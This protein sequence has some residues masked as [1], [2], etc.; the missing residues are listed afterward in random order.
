MTGSCKKGVFEPI[1]STLVAIRDDRVIE[2]A[3]SLA[4]S[5]LLAI[6]PLL[7]LALAL[8]T[9]FPIFADFEA[10]L[11]N[12]LVEQLMPESF[13]ATVMGYLNTFA[14]QSSKLSTI[15]GIFLVITALLI[16]FSVESALNKLWH[17]NE[18]R[19]LAKR[20]FIFIVFLLLGPLVAGASLWTSAF[21]LHESL[22]LAPTLSIQTPYLTSAINIS[23]SAFACSWLF[24]VV[25]NCKVL[26]RYALIGGLFTAVCL[27][28]VRLGLAFY[29]QQFPTYTV[30]YGAFSVLPAF[31]I[32][33]YLS[34]VAFLSGA[35]LAANLGRL[36]QSA[37]N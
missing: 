7:V 32:W 11:R 25:P 24:V 34:W 17:V 13:S 1:H 6:V 9:A 35:T 2:I 23:L 21:L 29:L 37:Q 26:W 3:G 27:E 4:F 30:I 28:S 16:V 12:F 20:L 18:N 10:A 22:G 8:F 19:G 31:L 33:V 36:N 14:Q 15:G 5:S